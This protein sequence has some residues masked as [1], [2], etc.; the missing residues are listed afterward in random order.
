MSVDTDLSSRTGR[1]D[2][3]ATR[4]TTPTLARLAAHSLNAARF[5]FSVVGAAITA[6]MPMQPTPSQRAADGT[7]SGAR[8]RRN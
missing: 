8:L 3:P 1:P 5:T 6:A 2:H 7:F 4:A